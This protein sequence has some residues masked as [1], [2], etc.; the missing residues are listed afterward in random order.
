MLNIY[1]ILLSASMLSFLS[2]TLSA[3]TLELDPKNSPITPKTQA[4]Q[5][6]QLQIKVRVKGTGKAIKRAEIK[7]S[8]SSEPVYSDPAG[9]ARFK[10]TLPADVEVSR[11]GYVTKKVSIFSEVQTQVFLNPKISPDNEI[12][13]TGKKRQE[14]SRKAISIN[15]AEKISVSGDAGRVAQLLPGVQ[16]SQTSS[17]IV[18][19]GSAPNDSLYFLDQLELP[20]LY[21]NVGYYTVVPNAFMSD[22][23]FTSGAFGVQ[24][25]DATGGVLS[26]QTTDQP[27]TERKLQWTLNL[28]LYVSAVYEQPIN[29]NSGLLI[30][31]RHSFIQYI[32]PEVIPED[33]GV[34]VAPAFSDA[35]FMYIHK[36]T[37]A[38]HK[39]K[40]V[41][42]L[43]GLELA[44]QGNN[45]SGENGTSNFSLDSSYVAASVERNYILGN[46]WSYTTEPQSY[47][48]KQSFDFFGNTFDLSVINARLP[49]ELTQRRGKNE[50]F[51][52]GLDYEYARATVKLDAPQFN[53]SDPFFDAETA[54]RQKIEKTSGNQQISAWAATDQKIGPV[55][56]HPGLRWMHNK[57]MRRST[58]DPRISLRLPIGRHQAKFATGIYSQSPEPPELDDDVGNPSLDYIQSVHYVAAVESKWSERWQTDFEVYYKDNRNQVQSDPVIAYNNDGK[59]WSYGIEAFIR[60]NL[61]NRWFGFLSYTFSNTRIKANDQAPVTPSEFDQT[62]VLNLAGNYKFTPTLDFGGRFTFRSG[63]RITEIDETLYDLDFDKYLPQVDP[64]DIFGDRLPNFYQFDLYLQKKFLL[65]TW[66]LVGKVGV[67]FL[68]H[69]PQVFG[70]RYNFDYTASEDAKGAPAIPFIE[71]QGNL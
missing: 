56:V 44:S 20:S 22:I 1:K 38:T 48:S 53:R 8:G 36:G 66:N 45:S 32:L 24:N 61:D 43:D 4:Q 6:D 55:F 25:G 54:P 40:V 47:Y 37:K 9:I 67:Q 63:D 16:T 21:H 13:I 33:A 41:Y 26:I 3:Q 69:K 59:L 60:R 65:N 28:P 18:V 57:N 64:K 39:V 17:K 14:V 30:A 70:R 50:K 23:Q 12:V 2:N 51:Y 27:P 49:L 68:A 62:H 5:Q 11:N 19:R 52:Y 15:E 35:S 7:V 46:G 29:E 58:V 71:L 10:A 42:F 31:G 34:T